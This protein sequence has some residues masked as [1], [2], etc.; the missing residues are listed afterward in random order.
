MPDPS[1]VVERLAFR[2]NAAPSPVVDYV[3]ALGL[4]TVFTAVRVGI[5]D[6]LQRGRRTAEQLAHELVLDPRGAETLLDALEAV[7]YVRR[8][9]ENY[10]ITAMAAK[11]MPRFA[12]G[13]DFF[14]WMAGD[15]WDDLP[16]RLRGA[17]ATE[18]DR[19]WVAGDS[20]E[21]NFAGMVSTA[22]MAADEVVRRVPVGRGPVRLLDLAGGSGV[23]AARFARAHPDLAATVIDLPEVIERARSVQAEEGVGDRVELRAAD[24]WT[25]DLGEGYDVVLLCNLLNA[26]DEAG[27][28]RLVARAHATLRPGG[29]IAVYDQMRRSVAAGT[30]R[31]VVELTNLRLFDPAHGGTYALPE[32]RAV[33]AAAG[34]SAVRS[35]KLFSVPW[36]T[37][38]T[39]R[40]TAIRSP[41]GDR[42][43][44]YVD[45]GEGART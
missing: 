11:W 29:T 14:E 3:G 15:G 7:G 16:D 21:D 23:F 40:C 5:F 6:A 24:M 9:G 17:A 39:A 18:A 34:F 4:R 8:T 28:H 2:A 35:R 30:A 32:L 44:A 19:T 31:A 12:E 27:R 45:A 22:R 42:G 26:Y 25:D 10:A 1:T 38:V 41:A 20:A 33:L 13:V 36:S 37:L 43:D